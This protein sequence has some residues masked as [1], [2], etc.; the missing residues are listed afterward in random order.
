MD[1]TKNIWERTRETGVE[2]KR[3]KG[4]RRTIVGRRNWMMKMRRKKM[5]R[6]RK[7]RRKRIMKMRRRWRRSDIYW[8]K[9][10]AAKQRGMPPLL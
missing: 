6:R 5:R 9:I 1:V 7:M 3:N 4:V 2:Q 8:F 10:L